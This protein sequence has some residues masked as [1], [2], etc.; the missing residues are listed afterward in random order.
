MNIPMFDITPPQPKFSLR[1]L[2]DR[3]TGK[4]ERDAW[5]A[6][7]RVGFHQ[8]LE[9]AAAYCERYGAHHE[10]ETGRPDIRRAA[11][12]VC[13]EHIRAVLPK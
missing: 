5:S 3:I 11:L 10:R 12:E 1:R 4:A 7:N 13:A 8:G 6:G 9:C 2:W